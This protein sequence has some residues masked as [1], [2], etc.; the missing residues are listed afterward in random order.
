LEE[1]RVKELEYYEIMNTSDE[2][3]YNEITK[4]SSYNCGKS[5]SLINFVDINKIW[6]KSLRGIEGLTELNRKESFCHL[7]INNK[8]KKEIFEIKN[9]QNHIRIKY[10]DIP[11]PEDFRFKF[12]AGFP[13]TTVQGHNIGTLCVLDYQQ[14]E[15]TNEQKN[16]LSILA[17]NR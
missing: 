3:D 17:Y 6:V 4:L 15:L 11:A 5:I 10:L 12:Y 13:L 8:K 7:T 2:E 16:A 1:K 9:T 14:E